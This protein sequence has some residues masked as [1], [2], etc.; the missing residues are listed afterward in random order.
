MAKRSCGSDF[1]SGRLR[2]TGANVQEEARL[3]LFPN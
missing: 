2:H 3:E 1:C